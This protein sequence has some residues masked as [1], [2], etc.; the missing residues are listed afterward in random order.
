MMRPETLANGKGEL[1]NTG[2]VLLAHKPFNFIRARRQNL[3]SPRRFSEFNP[4][5]LVQRA[6]RAHKVFLVLVLC[7]IYKLMD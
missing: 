6:Q 7:P 1:N 4:P 2:K 3:G 5:F